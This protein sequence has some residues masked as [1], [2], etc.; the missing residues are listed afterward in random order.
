[1]SLDYIISSKTNFVALATHRANR[2]NLG[3]PFRIM[4]EGTTNL[5]G[6][7]VNIISAGGAITGILAI[8]AWIMEDDFN[9]VLFGISAV[10]GIL[11]LIVLLNVH[12]IDGDKQHPV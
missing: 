12:E 11:I 7:I 5:W 1:M 8:F 4:D 9:P 3:L 10:G 2:S 6:W